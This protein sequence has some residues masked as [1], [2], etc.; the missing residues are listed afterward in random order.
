MSKSMGIGFTS[1]IRKW[2]KLKILW[3]EEAI[4]SFIDKDND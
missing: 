1:M 4:Y 2:H 3:L